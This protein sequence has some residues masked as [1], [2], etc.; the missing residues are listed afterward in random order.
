MRER[1][2][3][4][5][6]AT[7]LLPN[8]P[9]SAADDDDLEG[10]GDAGDDWGE[11]LFI[12]SGS[13]DGEERRG[14]PRV[15]AAVPVTYFIG[16]AQ[17]IGRAHNVSRSGIY[18]ETDQA[19]PVEGSRIN[20]RLPV[21]HAGKY[22]VVMLTTFVVRFKEDHEKPGTHPGFGARFKV[23]DELGVPGIFSHFLKS[24]LS[25]AG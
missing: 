24:Q 3:R 14:R 12:A 16:A 18:V 5:L 10:A 1:I 15:T 17:H 2:E 4:S 13:Y 22:H 6:S 9:R 23:V 7:A 21:A 20:I 25:K 8:P 11:P 19:M